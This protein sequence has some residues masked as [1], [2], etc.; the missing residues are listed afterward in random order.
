MLCRAVLCCTGPGQG[1]R[2]A[3]ED[4]HQMMEALKAHW[5]NAQAVAKQYEVRRP[6][7]D[8]PGDTACSGTRQAVSIPHQ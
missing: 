4:A 6:M 5:P 8:T 3:F 2:T 7:H 1:A